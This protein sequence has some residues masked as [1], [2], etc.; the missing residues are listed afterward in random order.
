VIAPFRHF[1]LK[2]V[3]LAL[4]TLLWMVVAREEPVERGL[5]IP[6]ELQQFPS[7]LELKGEAP[8]LVDVRVRGASDAL[9]RMGS[10]DIVA[11]LDLHAATPGQR[12][13]QLTPEQV[14]VP[15]GVQV[16]QVAPAT[17][18]LAFEKSATRQV[19]VMP[20][21]EGTPAAGFVIATTI[22]DPKMV[23]VTGPE[24]AID[25]VAAAVTEPVSVAGARETVSEMVTV[26]FLD[27]A[28]RVK[29]PAVVRVTVQVR[30]G[31]GRH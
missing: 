21:V 15:F 18:V 9:S 23:E 28:L 24:S 31:S 10:G 19:P 2:L 26:G 27:P 22:S 30:A 7:G 11:M 1:G 12:L 6:L 4:A 17:I 16:L 29:G 8:S 14:R 5:R 20:A 13:F 25:R 3:S